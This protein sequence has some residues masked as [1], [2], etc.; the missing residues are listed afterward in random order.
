[1]K[2]LEMYFAETALTWGFH[3]ETGSSAGEF[4]TGSAE[5]IV[6]VW[7][8]DEQNSEACVDTSISLN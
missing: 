7:I 5:F 2:L 6:P 3:I 4:A 8:L 1:M